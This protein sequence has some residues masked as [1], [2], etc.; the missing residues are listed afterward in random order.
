M[1]DRRGHT[2]VELLMV[3]AILGILM[4]V[5]LSLYGGRGKTDAERAVNSPRGRAKG[6]SC[7]NNVHQIAL[8][9]Q[10]ATV[11]SEERPQSL[12]VAKRNGVPDEML[13]CPNSNQPYAYNPET[14]VVACPTPGHERHTRQVT[15]LEARDQ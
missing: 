3:I 14:G 1:I 11:T 5:G 15:G 12:E 8:A 2:L 6:V 4:A 9:L 10:A 7:I 13:R